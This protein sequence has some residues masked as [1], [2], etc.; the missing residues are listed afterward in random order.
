MSSLGSVTR[1]N[2]SSRMS[3]GESR[4]PRPLP[5]S[6]GNGRSDGATLFTV[7]V[8]PSPS[9][10][11]TRGRA[12]LFGLN[13]LRREHRR[14]TIPGYRLYQLVNDRRIPSDAGYPLLPFVR[15]FQRN[16]LHQYR[17]WSYLIW[18]PTDR[19]FHKTHSIWRF[20]KKLV[21]ALFVSHIVLYI[22]MFF[23]SFGRGAASHIVNF[24]GHFRSFARSSS[25]P[26]WNG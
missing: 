14:K 3:T 24:P 22:I 1:S 23:S 9:P 16:R 2:G 26:S 8:R 15:R 17:R 20:I 13:L 10:R 4:F 11:P 5:A 18:Y 21:I 25:H 19:E 6:S 7:L 12:F